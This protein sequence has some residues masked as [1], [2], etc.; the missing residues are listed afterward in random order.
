MAVTAGNT[1]ALAADAMLK[2][3]PPIQYVKICDQYGAGFFVIPGTQTCLQLRGSIQIDM[4]FQPTKDLVFVTQ[5]KGNYVNSGITFQA[6][7][8]QEKWGYEVNVKP[9]F[10][11]RHETS[12]GT[13]RAYVELKGAIDA[14]TFNDPTNFNSSGSVFSSGVNGPSEIN[15]FSIYRAY[16]QWVGFTLGEA[17]SVFSTGGFKDGDLQNVITGEKQNSY[18]FSYTWTPS[19]PGQPPKKGGAP[20]PDGWSATI[21]AEMG[22]KYVAKSYFGNGANADVQLLAAA[23]GNPVGLGTV[24][25]QKGPLDWPD[26]VGRIHYEADPAG[27]DEQFNDQWSIGTFHLAGQWHN[28]D[29]ISQAGTPA[30]AVTGCPITAINCNPVNGQTKHDSGYAVGADLKVFTPMWGP[31]K[32]GSIAGADV[33]S[34]WFE[35]VY[36]VADSVAAG[37]GG[38]NGNLYSGDA[39]WMGGLVFDDG[40]FH[41]VNNGHGFYYL[42]KTSVFSFNVQ[43]HHIITD[44]TDPV[45]CWRFNVAYN[46]AK[47]MPGP[48]AQLVDWTLGGAGTA[49]K[50]SVTANVIWGANRP[51]TSV[52]TSAEVSFEVQY[53]WVNRALPGNCNGGQSACIAP[54]DPGLFGVSPNTNNW[55]G[56]LTITKGW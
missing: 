44:C 11:A 32:K 47:V 36:A 20:V 14:G 51:P 6:A 49:N 2:K 53:N 16:I 15:T 50:N 26:I 19:G 38:T 48:I 54:T 29:L 33:D 23:G 12:W 9:K 17:D 10:D 31:A 18:L 5:S 1:G 8:A 13:F 46:Y 55:V 41:L 39:Y 45:N 27:K 24:A 43:Y 40:D 28:I 52:P 30:L 42:D 56:R 37:V 35:A 22:T 4:A 7:G 25:A 21:S 3:A 34:L